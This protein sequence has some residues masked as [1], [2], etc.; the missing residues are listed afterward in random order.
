MERIS[1]QRQQPCEPPSVRLAPVHMSHIIDKQHA[2][3]RI[4]GGPRDSNVHGGESDIIPRQRLRPHI[5]PTH[6][7][8]PRDCRAGE[9]KAQLSCPLAVGFD[10][11]D[12]D[13]AGAGDVDGGLE[14]GKHAAEGEVEQVEG[15]G[16]VGRG[17]EGRDG[18]VGVQ[19]WVAGQN[20]VGDEQGYCLG[21]ALELEVAGGEGLRQAGA[22]L[23]S[24]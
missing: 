17:G 24:C 21:W 19:S 5:R 23:G 15:P 14:E 12:G 4:D 1:R 16:A 3:R 13:V 10:A 9:R 22:M 2:H 11:R 6:R 8:P 20:V 18:E 7:V